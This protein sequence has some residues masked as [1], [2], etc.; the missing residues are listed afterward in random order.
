MVIQIMEAVTRLILP[1]L[2]HGHYGSGH[3]RF[4]ACIIEP[5]LTRRQQ[6]ARHGLLRQGYNDRQREA[7]G[8]M[9]AFMFGWNPPTHRRSK[10]VSTISRIA[11]QEH[12]HADYPRH[13][14]GEGRDE[15]RQRRKPLHIVPAMD[16]WGN[17]ITYVDNVVFK[18]HDKGVGEWTSQGIRLM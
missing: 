11:R 6:S 3:E 7:F 12:I 5:A 17:K 13:S 15:A 16:L 9:V 1:T 10:V 2:K 14:R 4:K 8:E 18:Y